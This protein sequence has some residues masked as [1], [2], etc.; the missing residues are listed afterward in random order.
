MPLKS[1]DIPSIIRNKGTEK[2]IIYIVQMLAED[3]SIMR[4]ELKEAATQIIKMSDILVNIAQYNADTMEVMQKMS[5]IAEGEDGI[6]DD[7][8]FQGGNG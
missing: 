4:Q 6:D 3:N 5:K 8:S 7:N 1:R 2:G